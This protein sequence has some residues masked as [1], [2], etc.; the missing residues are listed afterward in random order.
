MISKTRAEI[1]S[2]IVLGQFDCDKK[3]KEGVIT[4]VACDSWAP[5]VTS[6]KVV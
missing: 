5:G 1:L 2:Y 3:S 4:L 6:I